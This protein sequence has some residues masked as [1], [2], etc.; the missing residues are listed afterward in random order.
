VT[1]LCAF[2]GIFCSLSFG[3]TR[4]WLVI[5]DKSL[6]NWFDF[7]TGQILLP[8]G[9]LFTCLFIGWYVPRQIVREEL[10]NNGTLR[11]RVFEVYLFSV[12]YVCP[13]GILLIFLHQFGVI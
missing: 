2:I 8:T 9:G 1:I 4:D 7:L 13:L 11:S 3:D 12:R 10:T 5:G 6:F